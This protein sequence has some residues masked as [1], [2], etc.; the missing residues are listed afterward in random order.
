MRRNDACV[1]QRIATRYLLEL[2]V[3]VP[4]PITELVHPNPIVVRQQAT[5]GIEV[6]DVIDFAVATLVIAVLQYGEGRALDRPEEMTEGELLLIVDVL[7]G[8][9]EYGMAIERRH[10]RGDCVHVE[11]LAQVDPA[12]SGRH[13]RRS[14]FRRPRQGNS[15]VG[16]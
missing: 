13:P 6:R 7:A 10:Q 8:K 14:A 15:R 9:D 2:T 11:R 12:D 4:E 1:Q 5:F 16:K 3:R